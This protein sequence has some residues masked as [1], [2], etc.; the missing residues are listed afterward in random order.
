MCSTCCWNAHW[1]RGFHSAIF[2]KTV[3]C[4]DKSPGSRTDWNCKKVWSLGGQKPRKMD[5]FSMKPASCGGQKL[6]EITLGAFEKYIRYDIPSPI[7]PMTIAMLDGRRLLLMIFHCC[8]HISCKCQAAAILW[9]VKGGDTSLL[10]VVSVYAMI[11]ATKIPLGAT[12]LFVLYV[13]HFQLQTLKPLKQQCR[14][15]Y[16][17]YRSSRRRVLSRLKSSPRENVQ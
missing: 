5:G 10:L 6:R 11:A 13:Y 15:A 8:P 17:S 3:F 12:S 9:W 14:D 1:K 16:C 7:G 4:L 2:A